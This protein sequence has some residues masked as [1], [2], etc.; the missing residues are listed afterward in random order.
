[1]QWLRTHTTRLRPGQLVTEKFALTLGVK[2]AFSEQLMASIRPMF[3]QVASWRREAPDTAGVRGVDP[4]HQSLVIR[5][6]EEAELDEV[7]NGVL[8]ERIDGISSLMI[9]TLLAA[10]QKRMNDDPSLVD[11]ANQYL[12][13]SGYSSFSEFLRQTTSPGLKAI[14]SLVWVAIANVPNK[15]IERIARVIR[16]SSWLIRE[17]AN[18]NDAVFVPLRAALG[19][20]ILDDDAPIGPAR[21]QRMLIADYGTEKEHLEFTE[22]TMQWV[23]DVGLNDGL[24]RHGTHRLGCPAL[25]VRIND[26]DA[27][28]DSVNWAVE[29][30]IAFRHRFFPR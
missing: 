28:T 30:L 15:D 8:R 17:W 22:E 25:G 21:P 3:E 27:I 24:V 5:N 16:N 14:S 23:R 2:Q 12:E 10:F 13:I 18:Q 19:N 11:G 4:S 7:I 26:T 29:I 20:R 9:T 1:M 6:L